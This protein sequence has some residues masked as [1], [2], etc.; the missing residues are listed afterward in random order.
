MFEQEYH[1]SFEEMDAAAVYGE[2]YMKLVGDNRVHD[3][4]LDPGHPV[5]VVFDIGSSGMHSDATAWIAF[6][7][8]NG[9]LFLYDCGEGHGK[10]LP[11]YVDV[12]QAKQYFN[13]V[14]A[15][16]LP[17]DGDH[18]EKAVNTTP[19]DMM[20]QRFPNVAVLAKSN[21][22]WKIPGSRSGDFNIVTDIQQT[23]MMLYNTII[24]ET[25]CQ[26]LLECLE[27]YKYEFN[28]RLQMWTQQ[29]LHDKHIHMMDALRY[30]VQA[31]KELDFFS[32][33]FFDLP[34]QDTG[35]IDY[36]QDYSGVWAR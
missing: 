10:A 31:V 13:K 5:Y 4:N 32:G 36:V 22:V 2:A 3:F 28:T 1:V 7:W 23:R 30:A 29:P 34:G 16:I 18:H 26:W 12:L 17:W 9:R 8:I 19:A 24:H 15:M 25:N 11:E 21:K 20:R 14:G 35:S 27:N 33:K 6:Q